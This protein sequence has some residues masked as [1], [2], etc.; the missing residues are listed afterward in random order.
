MHNHKKAVLVTNVGSEMQPHP[1]SQPNQN[2][3]DE[4]QRIP[5]FD[6]IQPFEDGTGKLS[7]R[8]GL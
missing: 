8:K 6:V 3:D 5:D 4:A 7:R 2:D 1:L